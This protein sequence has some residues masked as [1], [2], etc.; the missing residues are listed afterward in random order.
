MAIDLYWDD[1]AQTV[2]LA[3]FNGKWTWD[4]L[5]KMIS[6]IKSLSYER[7][8]IFGAII[9]LRNG[10]HLPGGN[11]FSKES[12]DRFKQLLSLNDG[13][14]RQ[15]PVA[16]LGVNGVI[17]MIFEAIKN[18]DASV[19]EDVLFAKDEAEAREYIYSAVARINSKR[20][21]A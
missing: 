17:K 4:E 5:H 16:V 18:V 1:D 7:D 9:D 10:M 3:E 2:L 19:V 20:A 13:D 15:G 21:Q 12:L 6:K 8:M 14:N 11:I